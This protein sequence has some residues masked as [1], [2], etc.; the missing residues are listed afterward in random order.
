MTAGRML[1]SAALAAALAAL[2][3]YPGVG[4]PLPGL[5]FGAAFLFLVVQQDVARA[6]IPNA[7][8]LPALALALV[9]SAALQGWLGLGWSLIGA[10]LILAILGVPFAVHA[11]GA[12]DVKALMVLGALWGPANAL[13]VLWWGTLLAGAV[14]AL[15]LLE[16]RGWVELAARWARSLTSSGSARR[17]LYEPPPATAVAAGRLRFGAVLGFAVPAFRCWGVPW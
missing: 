12:G 4:R 14:A 17:V 6:R 11:V 15:L 13:G 7:L 2:C 1:G 10:G 3:L 8:T 5:G 9:H 16:R